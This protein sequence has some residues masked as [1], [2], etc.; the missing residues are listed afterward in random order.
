MRRSNFRVPAV[1]MLPLLLIVSSCA[2]TQPT[3][4]VTSGGGPGMGQAQAIPYNGP[5]ARIAV[6]KFTDKSAKGYYQIGD[7]LADMLA[8]ELFHTN[9]FIV[10]ER[11]QL[12]EVL[13]EQDLA[14]AGRIKAGTEAPTG[15]IE[16]AELLITGAVTEFEPNAGGVGGGV[17][18]GGLPLGLGGGGK[19][20]HIAIDLRVIDTKTSRILA[21]TTVEGK[22]T[23][24]AG[25]IGFGIGGGASQLGVGLGGYAKTPMEKAI[26]LAIKAGVNFIAGQTPAQYYH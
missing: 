14:T 8:T 15:E 7:G 3:A 1:A 10:L 23:D 12:G 25:G 26:R 18:F 5:Q 20:A 9:R 22:A 2:M 17:I 24:I 11:Q 16:G 19:K 6:S 21:A 13:Q 4:T